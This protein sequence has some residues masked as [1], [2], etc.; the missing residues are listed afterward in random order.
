MSTKTPDTRKPT[1][2]RRGRELPGAVQDRPEQNAG[3]DEA[4]RGRGRGTPVEPQDEAEVVD[5]DEELGRRG[6][7]IEGEEG[8]E[9]EE[10]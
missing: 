3:Y 8:K 5:L 10:R 7:R 2:G 9:D 4:V 6:I 1:R